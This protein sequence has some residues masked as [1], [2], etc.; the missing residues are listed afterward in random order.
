MAKEIEIMQIN[1]PFKG[2]VFPSEKQIN[3]E[4]RRAK[5]SI[6]TNA[7]IKADPEFAK[8]KQ[9]GALKT[10][11]KRRKIPV[12][13]RKSIMLEYWD[14]QNARPLYFT[15]IIAERYN[16]QVGAI[17]K[18][19][20]N[21]HNTLTDKQYIKLTEKYN[22]KFG[23][24]DIMNQIYASGKRDTKKIGEKISLAKNTVTRENALK[25]YDLCLTTK[26][27]RSHNYYYKLAEQFDVSFSKIQSIANGHHPALKNKDV[28]KDIF[29]WQK[30]VLGIFEFTSPEG[31][32]YVFDN[33]YDVGAF[34]WKTEHGLTKTSQQNWGK[35]RMWFEKTKPN[36][37]YIKRRRFWK[38]WEYINIIK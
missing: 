23:R 9:D 11:E 6:T 20:M 3:E 27:S 36:T 17:E 24:S 12:E 21:Y 33:L 28:K 31:K 22:S 19:I 4:T 18:I 5:I 29:D 14:R 32:K 15:K 13:D 26:H 8:I 34:L 1:D 37:V 16:V 25:I 38:G 2:F 7:K 30:R 35:G 10:A